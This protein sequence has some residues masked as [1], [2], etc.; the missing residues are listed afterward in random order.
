[1]KATIEEKFKDNIKRI[2]ETN[3]LEWQMCIISTGYGKMSIGD[4]RE[5]LT[6]RFAWEL[7]HGPIPKGLFVLHKCD[8]PRCCNVEHLFL[9]KH[10]ENAQDM[11]NKMRSNWG[12]RCTFCKLTPLQVLQVIEITSKTRGGYAKI[13]KIFNVHYNTVER[14]ANRRTWLHLFEILDESA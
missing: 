11:A 1:M 7:K 14:I 3:C 5:M 6:H 2:P 4:G 13:G 9:G 10:K 8:N 12:E